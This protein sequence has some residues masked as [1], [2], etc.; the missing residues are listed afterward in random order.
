M[1]KYILSSGLSIISK[2]PTFESPQLS[3]SITN[4]I[5]HAIQFDTIGEAMKV[6]SKINEMLKY[7]SYKVVSVEID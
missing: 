1:T 6:A 3:Y 5:E 7:A 4:V 2:I